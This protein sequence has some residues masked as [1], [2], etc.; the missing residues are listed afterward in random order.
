[1]DRQTDKWHKFNILPHSTSLHGGIITTP[2]IYYHKISKSQ[3]INFITDVVVTDRF[4]CIRHIISSCLAV[5]FAQSIEARCQVENEDVLGAVST[6]S[7]LTKPEWTAL[8]FPMV[9]L[10]LDV[11][12]NHS[13]LMMSYDIINLG[14][15]WFMYWI[16]SSKNAVFLM[17][18]SHYLNIC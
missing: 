2:Y 16:I 17:V 14:Q 15:Q 11:D 4:H 10:I 7:A 18:S 5:V 8:L 12:F 13:G 3:A 6:G 1:M 9:W